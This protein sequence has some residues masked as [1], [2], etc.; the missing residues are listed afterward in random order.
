MTRSGAQ[1]RL[2]PREYGY[3]NTIYRR[4]TRRS[5]HGIFEQLYQELVDDADLEHL[6]IDSLIN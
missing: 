2:L 1:W 6:L 3:W 5:E 4:F